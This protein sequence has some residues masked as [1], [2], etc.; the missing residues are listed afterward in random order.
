MMINATTADAAVIVM[1]RMFDASRDKVWAAFTDPKHVSKW[2]GGHGFTNPVCEMDV[3][4]GGVWRHVMRTPDGQEYRQEFVF[5]EV[6]KPEKLVWQSRDHGKVK[7]GGPPTCV[8]TV[9]LEE[10]GKQTKW[11]LVAKFDSI[12][13]RNAATTMGFAEM[14]EQGCEKF[15]EIVSAL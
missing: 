9:T 1:S 6:S 5:V 8:M 12:A 15:N 11:T 3:R 4:P 14:I 10:A 2:Y 7:S 13:D